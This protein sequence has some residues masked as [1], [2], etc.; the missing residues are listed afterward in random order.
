MKL[1]TFKTEYHKDSDGNIV[2]TECVGFGLGTD[3]SRE[4]KHKSTALDILLNSA[5][6]HEESLNEH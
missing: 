5:K 3:E 2:K 1:H 4:K 6:K